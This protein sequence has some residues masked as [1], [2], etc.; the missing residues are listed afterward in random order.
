M[1]RIYNPDADMWFFG[2]IGSPNLWVSDDVNAAD[3]YDN[4]NTAK[5]RA[6]QILEHATTISHLII[7]DEAGETVWHVRKLVNHLA[8]VFINFSRY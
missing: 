7:E 3:T 2:R 5:K 8:Q 1:N 4:L 6:R